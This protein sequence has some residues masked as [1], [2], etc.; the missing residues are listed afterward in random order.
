MGQRRTRWNGK[1]FAYS[2][3]IGFVSGIALAQLADQWT[4]GGD[5]VV[6]ADPDK[7]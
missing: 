4:I 6:T 1:V 3:H 2:P 5:E 7:G